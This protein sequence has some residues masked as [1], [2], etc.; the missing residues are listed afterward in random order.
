MILCRHC[1][2]F[3]GFGAAGVAKQPEGKDRQW[4][5]THCW[6]CEKSEDE[7]RAENERRVA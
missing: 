6:V 5:A 4:L 2:V 3:V 1:D 7:V